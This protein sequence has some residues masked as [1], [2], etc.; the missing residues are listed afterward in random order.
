M[1]VLPT[2]ASAGLVVAL[3]AGGASITAVASG[4]HSSFS[5]RAA[6]L[7]RAWT[8]DVA[9]GVSA[10]SI[11]PLRQKLQ[12]SQDLTASWW[13]PHWWGDTGQALLNELQKQTDAAWS[14]AMSVARRDAE[15]AVAAWSQLAA[16]LGSFIPAAASA[17]AATWPAKIASAKTPD[18]LTG[19]ARS[20]AT[21]IGTARAEAQTAQLNAQKASLDAQ[22][23]GFG[24]V[25]GLL[26]DAQRAVATGQADNLDVGQVPALIATVQAQ[27]QSGADAGAS[28]QQLVSALTG[29]Q[30]LISLNDK[31]ASLEQ[32]LLWTID[33]AAAESTPNA[34]GFQ[35]QYAS[36]Q[37]AFRN[38][39]EAAQLTTVQQQMNALTATVN[40]EL[41]TNQCGHNVGA[42]K[43]ITLNLTLQ[44]AVFYQ[45]GCAVRA[46]P[47]T[48]GRAL[49]RTP[50]GRFH[51]FYKT[52]P[53]QFISPWPP[54]SPFYY[55]PS[56]TSWV[57][58]FASGGYFI[59]D[60]P[61]EPGG[62]YG[63]GSENS[64]GASHGCVHIPTPTMQ[65]LYQWTPNGTP[66]IIT[67]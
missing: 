65:W 42:G 29:L 15:V 21:E 55:Y 16:Q 60:A 32:P 46:T 51:V 19:L 33:Q 7:E 67:N 2:A 47:I 40:Q 62:E 50:T 9:V 27:F 8:H 23:A 61:W 39:T 63:P 49:L 24:G 37:N 36:V 13:S 3:V 41:S 11:A 6:A 48:T 53:F 14:S 56:W 5:V 25:S 4:R 17:D 22:V 26:K 54:S 30:S 1:R 52:S 28:L 59:H 10:A 20:W 45:D 35:A 34:G 64:S 38:A 58:E 44:E 18:E 57:M 66:V 12:Q 31:V 43:V